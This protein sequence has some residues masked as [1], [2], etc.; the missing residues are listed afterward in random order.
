MIGYIYRIQHTQSD[1][2]YVGSTF[3]GVAHR[4]KQHKSVFDKWLNHNGPCAASIY[5]HMKEHGIE[6]FKCF[7]VKEYDVVDRKHL[8][9]YESL[10]IKKLKSCNKLIPFAIRKLSLKDA[11]LKDRENRC[12][13]VRAYVAANKE[14]I[15][16]RN[17]AYRENNK[18]IIRAKKSE[19]I[20][21]ECGGSW[22]K[23]H[24]VDRH[25]KTKKHQNWVSNQS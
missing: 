18:E 4:W 22:S 9:V 16:Q 5:Y 21:C 15:T 19:R 7:L 12:A 20:Q 8:E 13:K 11:Y 25:E 24:G 10:W 2:C 14:L 6:Q 23:G 17:K 1:L 3:N